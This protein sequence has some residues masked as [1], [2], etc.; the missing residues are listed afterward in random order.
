METQYI[1][2]IR[3]HISKFF[4]ASHFTSEACCDGIPSEKRVAILMMMIVVM[5]DYQIELLQSIANQF[6]DPPIRILP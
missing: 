4:D 2:P 6:P 3:D 5:M 1:Q